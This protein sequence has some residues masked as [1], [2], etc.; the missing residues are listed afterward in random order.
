M[1]VWY[2]FSMGIVLIIAVVSII[3]A[4]VSL[5]GQLSSLQETQEAKKNLS[6]NRVV[7]QSDSS[8][9]E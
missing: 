4:L 3:W 1:I 9:D 5:K 6:K 8:A 2:T 7:F